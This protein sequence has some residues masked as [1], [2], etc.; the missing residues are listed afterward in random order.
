MPAAI[1]ETAMKRT[2]RTWVIL[3]AMLLVPIAWPAQ[4]DDFYR[5][6]TI[7][8]IVAS[9]PAGGYDLYARLLGR[10]MGKYL[11]GNPTFV[12][13]N[14]PGAGGVR[15]AQFLSNVARKDGTVIGVITREAPLIPLLEPDKGVQFN[16][17]AFNWIGSPQ[18]EIGLLI[19]N[20]RAPAQTLDELKQKPI[21]VS[22]TGPGTAPSVFPRIL[23]DVLGT[24]FKV[25]DGY[26]GSQE[27]LFAVEKGEVD[28]HV[29][30][31]SSSGFRARIDPWIAKG[32]ARIL[33][34][35]G[36]RKTDAYAQAPL[37]LDLVADGDDRRLLELVFSP[38]LMGRPFVAPP[39][40]P[41]EH[42]ALLQAAFDRTMRDPE[43][44]AEAQKQQLEINP[45]GGAE[46]GRLIERVYGMPSGLIE[47][48]RR[49]M[50]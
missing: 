28:G 39:G 13:Q 36:F 9:A 26:A 44:L 19:V 16:A 6:K 45:V 40:L 10:H 37:A 32:Q 22:A 8:V 1:E 23:N 30:G 7:D 42:V 17:A 35:M 21:T 4:A 27:A 15:A 41:P 14:M 29:S 20:A 33:M 38:Q 24:R 47:R 50:K 48:A 25:I 2:G 12:V 43:F 5:G 49:A 34:Q 3:L 18:Q 31:G 11:P 46:I